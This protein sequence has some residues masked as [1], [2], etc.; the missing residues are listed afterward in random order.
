MLTS[1]RRYRYWLLL[2]VVL[3][4]LPGIAC[5]TG[6]GLDIISHQLSVRQ[7]TGDLNGTKSIAIVSGQARNI[8][9]VSIDNPVIE[10]TFF[11]GQ[12]NIIGTASASR[13][14]LEPGEIWNF[15]AQLTSPDAWKVRDSR[16]T[17][18]AK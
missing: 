7:F 3:L 6:A 10:V 16:I 15:S 5:A 18:S 2:L 12:K 8:S 13:R 11:D 14:F 9:N 4:I 1:S 17:G